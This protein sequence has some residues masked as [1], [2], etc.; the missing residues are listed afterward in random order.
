MGIFSIFP[1]P[2]FWKETEEKKLLYGVRLYE[3]NENFN[4][5]YSTEV[6]LEI[7]LFCRLT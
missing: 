3:E 7:N 1:S 6:E 5:V 4:F 2:K